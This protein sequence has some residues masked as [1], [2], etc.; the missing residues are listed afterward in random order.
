MRVVL[1]LL[2]A[3]IAVIALLACDAGKP[4]QLFHALAEPSIL[5]G[6]VTSAAGTV[7]RVPLTRV[8]DFRAHKNDQ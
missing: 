4:P 6:V 7:K 1:C 5:A 8:G 3:V 2:L